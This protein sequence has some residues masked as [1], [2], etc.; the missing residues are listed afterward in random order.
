[1]GEGDTAVDS[2]VIIPEKLVGQLLNGRAKK[3]L[4]RWR[5]D[6]GP[7]GRFSGEEIPEP[8][9]RTKC[10]SSRLDIGMGSP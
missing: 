6:G 2:L 3:R 5:G 7:I 1:M 9:Q 4:Q 8:F 10:G